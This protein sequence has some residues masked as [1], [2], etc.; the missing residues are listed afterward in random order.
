MPARTPPKAA[1]VITST[2]ASRRAA[3]PPGAGAELRPDGRGRSIVQG[4]LTP[5]TVR[6]GTEAEAARRGRASLAQTETTRVTTDA[7]A[8]P[9]GAWRTLRRL[10]VT[11]AGTAM[12][13]AGVAMIVLPGPAIVAIP[14]GLAILGLEYAWARRALHR[15]QAKAARAAR[16]RSVTSDSGGPG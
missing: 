7:T 12:L 11:L 15:L 5:G 6:R 1:D 8:R 16:T 13:L 14:A 3:R 2:R 4:D 10:L 9:A